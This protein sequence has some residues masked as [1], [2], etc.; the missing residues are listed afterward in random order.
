MSFCSIGRAMFVAAALIT[1]GSV[2]LFLTVLAEIRQWQPP[3]A[4]SVLAGLAVRLVVVFVV[5]R[6]QTPIDA[7]D[8]FHRVGLAVRDGQDPLTS[9]PVGFWNFFPPMAYVFALASMLPIP[10]QV[11]EKIV[12]VAA[13]VTLIS[14]VGML[15]SDRPRLRQ[16]QYAL[17]PIAVLVSAFHGQF[18]SVA[19]AFGIAALIVADRGRPVAAGLLL[20]T[21]ISVKSW[22]VIFIPGVLRAFS[23]RRVPSIVAAAA[24]VPAISF[25]TMPLLL[26]THL[27]R[28]AKVIAGHTILPGTWGW[29]GLLRLAGHDPRSGNTIGTL[30][31]GAAFVAAWWSFRRLDPQRLSVVLFLAFSVFTAGYAPQYV[32]WGIPLLLVVGSRAGQMFLAAAGIYVVTGYAFLFRLHVDFPPARA[33]MAPVILVSLV[34]VATA[35]LVPYELSKGRPMTRFPARL[36]K[37]RTWG[38]LQ[39]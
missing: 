22:P 15:R 2:L 37:R 28:A 20:G 36:E 16:L 25:L 33:V 18:E 27:G 34:A 21:A 23:P 10:W 26:T 8:Y 29:S 7:T 17:S 4:V 38:G 32:L 31:A 19:L 6:N 35:L 24:V 1:T 3:V 39:Q 13:D 30:L 14:L 12:P 9:L 11:A 5:T